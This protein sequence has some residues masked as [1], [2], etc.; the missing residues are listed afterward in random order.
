MCQVQKNHAL[1]RPTM[2][3]AAEELAA[4][5]RLHDLRLAIYRHVCLAGRRLVAQALRHPASLGEQWLPAPLQGSLAW[6]RPPHRL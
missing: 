5:I 4:A 1:T 2:P 6:V 3:L